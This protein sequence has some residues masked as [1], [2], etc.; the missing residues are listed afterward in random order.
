MAV[1]VHAEGNG[2]PSVLTPFAALPETSRQLIGLAI[3]QSGQAFAYQ[4]DGCPD[5]HV[6]YLAVMNIATSRTRQWAI[7]ER[8]S[9]GSLSL[10]ANGNLLAYSDPLIKFVT[11]AASVLPADAAAGTAAERSRIIAQAARFGSLAEVTSDAIAPDGSALYFV[12]NLTGTA[13]ADE[14]NHETWQLRVADLATGQ[15][16]TVK[17]FAGFTG[18]VSADPSGR[19]LLL[20]LRPALVAA[21]QSVRLARLDIAT[22]QVAYLRTPW[23][24]SWASITW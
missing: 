20:Q 6:A 1:P 23:I 17:S 2:Q 9:I 11:S 19:Y 5:N 18:S 22:G 12:T 8:N 7:P 3:S 14:G 24:G 21:S 10:T 15:S 16:R 4:T 13:L